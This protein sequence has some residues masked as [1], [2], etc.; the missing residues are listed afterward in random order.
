MRGLNDGDLGVEVRDVMANLRRRRMQI[1]H[2]TFSLRDIRRLS[3][4]LLFDTVVYYV[5]IR[6][7]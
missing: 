5:L 6:K 1:P 7:L 3:T 4:H 2:V